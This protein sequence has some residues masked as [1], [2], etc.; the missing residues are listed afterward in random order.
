MRDAIDLKFC[1]IESQLIRNFWK[2]SYLELIKN[3]HIK[4]I[5]ILPW[6]SHARSVNY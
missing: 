4:Y 5:E 3:I 1:A 2:L 6:E